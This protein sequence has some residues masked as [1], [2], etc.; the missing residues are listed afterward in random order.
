MSIKD[1]ARQRQCDARRTLLLIICEEKKLHQSSA[2]TNFPLAM[3]IVRAIN[4]SKIFHRLGAENFAS[5]QV[6]NKSAGTLPSES[7]VS[8]A[9]AS[10]R[11]GT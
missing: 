4:S 11:R 7:K 2:L 10:S 8:T 1:A 9:S 3:T 6:T 5:M